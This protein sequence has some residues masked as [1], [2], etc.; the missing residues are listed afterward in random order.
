MNNNIL[1]AVVFTSLVLMLVCLLKPGTDNM[2]LSGFLSGLILYLTIY[3][4]WG[5][6]K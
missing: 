1:K 3:M 6:K 5:G 4:I 2:I